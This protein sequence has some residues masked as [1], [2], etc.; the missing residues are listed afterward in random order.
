MNISYASQIQQ[1]EGLEK[2]SGLLHLINK[3]EQTQTSY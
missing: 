2:H 3:D 1:T